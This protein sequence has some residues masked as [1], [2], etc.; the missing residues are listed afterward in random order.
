MRV[1]SH[2]SVSQRTHLPHH[3]EEKVMRRHL[4]SM[5]VFYQE[6]GSHVKK[7]LLNGVYRLFLII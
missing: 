1:C 7:T 6:K 4:V 3:T 5:K 2:G